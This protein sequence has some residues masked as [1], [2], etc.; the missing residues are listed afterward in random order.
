MQCQ[1][2]LLWVT[3]CVVVGVIFRFDVVVQPCFLLTS[4]I[5]SGRFCWEGGWMALVALSAG[6]CFRAPVCRLGNML[7][8]GFIWV[9]RIH[10]CVRVT[11][12]PVSSSECKTMSCVFTCPAVVYLTPVSVRFCL[13]SGYQFA[14]VQ[15]ETGREWVLNTDL[16]HGQHNTVS[17][18]PF[19]C[20]RM[21][22]NGI[23][24]SKENGVKD[25][26]RKTTRN[27][28]DSANYLTEKEDKSLP[29]WVSG[30]CQRTYLS[31]VN[32]N[33]E[34]A[35]ERHMLTATGSTFIPLQQPCARGGWHS[36]ISS[37]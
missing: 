33:V 36:C 30:K 15:E 26:S 29:H 4:D 9:G 35:I 25:Q 19:S 34:V 3:N 31:L 16:R 17:K 22:L 27:L 2:T 32:S 23:S 8:N 5:F 7:R 12:W 1:L 21:F 14:L 18:T 10:V 6:I 37:P 13:A 11:G 20:G 28:N 24:Q